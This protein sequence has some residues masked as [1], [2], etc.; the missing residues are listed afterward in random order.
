[1]V[2][3]AEE[4]P[5]HL[6]STINPTDLKPSYLIS[7]SSENGTKMVKTVVVVCGRCEGEDGGGLGRGVKGTETVV[8]LVFGVLDTKDLDI[9]VENLQNLSLY[10]I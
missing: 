9:I 2:V 8:D 7:S 10:K 1:M 4:E 3:A 5:S 6:R